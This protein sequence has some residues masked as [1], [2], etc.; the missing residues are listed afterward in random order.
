MRLNM[1]RIKTDFLSKGIY[2]LVMIAVSCSI[3]ACGSN[4]NNLTVDTE[5]TETDKVVTTTQDPSIVYASEDM[6]VEEL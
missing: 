2:M 1:S 5:N 4:V 3:L 6:S